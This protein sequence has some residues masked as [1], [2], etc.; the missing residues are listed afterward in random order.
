MAQVAG[1]P[2]RTGSARRRPR[3]RHLIFVGNA[4]HHGQRGAA[5]PAPRRAFKSESKQSR[6]RSVADQPPVRPAPDDDVDVGARARRR[7]ARGRRLGRRG[8]PRRRRRPSAARDH[9]PRRLRRVLCL[10][11]EKHGHDAA[12]ATILAATR[13]SSQSA[14]GARVCSRTAPSFSSTNTAPRRV[15]GAACTSLLTAGADVRVLVVGP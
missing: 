14:T 13:A 8:R 5:I 15:D 2:R 1:P 7:A 12:R 11:R 3:G 10:V 4:L 9:R 6:G